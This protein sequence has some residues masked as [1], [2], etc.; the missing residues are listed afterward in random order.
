MRDVNSLYKQVFTAN[1]EVRPVGREKC[2]ELIVAC[3]ELYKK[4]Y[5]EDVNF[6]DE[7]SGFM[8][9]D[10]IKQFMFSDFSKI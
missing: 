3:R 5:S 1:G 9:V 4:K 7:D 2:K 6:G 10:K 8:D